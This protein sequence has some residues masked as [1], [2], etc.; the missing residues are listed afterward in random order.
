MS[1]KVLNLEEIEQRCQY[2][3]L[4]QYPY[5]EQFR[6]AFKLLYV[7][8]CRI[9]EIFEISRWSSVSDTVFLVQPQKGNNVRQVILDSD[10]QAFK[11]AVLNQYSP[12]LGMSVYQFT[13]LLGRIRTWDYMF[14]GDKEISFYV[15]RY[16]YIKTLY[17]K[18]FTIEQI[19]AAMGYLEFNTVQNYIDAMITEEIGS[20]IYGW[21]RVGDLLW[22]R[23]YLRVDDGG[24]G[25]YVSGLGALANV[26]Y[27]YSY[28]AAGRVISRLGLGRLPTRDDFIALQDYLYELGFCP[29]NLKVGGSRFWNSPNLF[30]TNQ[31]NF[32]ALGLG[33]YY[34]GAIWKEL[35]YG[36]FMHQPLSSSRLNC[37]I[38]FNNSA[39]LGFGAFNVSVSACSVRLVLDL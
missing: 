20:D 12:F 8:G 31:F 2:L 11:S 4:C 10:F 28:E 14:S 13:N 36:C 1:S 5:Y 34:N 7:T 30:A 38:L 22:A 32:N 21:L 15:F 25:I 3:C 29:G 16:R 39:S 26:G 23:D 17:S 18:G 9:Q 33:Y 27:L 24:G 35:E 37:A 6:E 19:A